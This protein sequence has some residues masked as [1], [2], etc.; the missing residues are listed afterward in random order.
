VSDKDA[1]LRFNTL[2]RFSK[3]SPGLVLEEYRHWEVPV[4]CGG[5]MLQWRDPA[6][7]HLFVLRVATVG[8]AEVRLDGEP[9][10][11]LLLLRPGAHELQI[12][13]TDLPD[14]PSPFGLEITLRD[15]EEVLLSTASG[16]FLLQGSPPGLF[17]GDVE[18]A[19]GQRRWSFEGLDRSSLLSLPAG[20][21]LLTRRL[22]VLDA[23]SLR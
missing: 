7:G 15:E 21:A 13:I 12:E 3:R 1:D 19:S 14:H 9:V 18:Q 22:Q 20:R 16:G 5:V 10:R 4:G 8:R 6:D 11:N 23:K 17:T 2:H